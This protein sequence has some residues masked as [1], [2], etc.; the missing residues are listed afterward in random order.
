MT[1]RIAFIRQFAVRLTVLATAL[2]STAAVTQ[3]SGGWL[4]TGPFGG[5]AEIIR[6]VPKT[7][8]LVLAG[9]RNAILY[10]S[11]NGGAYWSHLPFPGEFAGTLHALEADPRSA[12]TWYVGLESQ[13]SYTA[14]VYKTVDAGRNWSIL[15]P[16]RGLQVW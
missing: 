5:D 16:T 2:V 7:K 11:I 10:V 12:S 14:G 6:T 8:G 13:N 9:T 15:E 3:A 4:A 1:N